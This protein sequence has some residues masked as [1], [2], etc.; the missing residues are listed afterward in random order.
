MNIDAY[1]QFKS[2]INYVNNRKVSVSKC[3][4]YLQK[5]TVNRATQEAH[6]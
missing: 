6:W 1:L 4:S 2:F 3:D 5:V